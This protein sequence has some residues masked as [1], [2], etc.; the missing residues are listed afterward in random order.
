[1][2][3]QGNT[4]LI[5]GGATGIGFALAEQ[6]TENNEVIICGRR[7]NKLEE[8]KSKLREL[9]T[10]ECD[11]TKPEERE[12]LFYYLTS[13]FKNFNILVNNAGIQ[14]R[15]D[16]K[17][18]IEGLQG[19]DEIEINLK[20]TVQLSALFIP[21]LLK[22]KES[23]IINVSSGLGFVP[24]ASVPI[25]C[26]TKAAIHYYTLS[27]RHQLKDTSI[28]VFEIIPPTTDTELDKG[29]R[30]NY[31]GVPALDVAKAAVKG[32]EQDE[33]E[34]AIGE[35]VGLREQSKTGFDEAFK[36]LNSY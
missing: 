25:Y 24:I 28:K 34:V 36:R 33:F 12:S 11:V 22:Q 3:L 23:A 16:L 31:R 14:K 13:N 5:T 20:A 2:K 17:K 30:K 26:A 15:I 10:F 35:A 1:M 27:L 32:I 29:Q 19:E 6:L 4:I 8:A 21:F 7:R 9:H 18:G